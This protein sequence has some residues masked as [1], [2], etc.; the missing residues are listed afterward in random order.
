MLVYI[1]SFWEG[2]EEV[3]AVSEPLVK[4]LR[5]IDG[6]K[7]AMGY[8]YEAMDRAK[9]TIRNYYVGKGTP[10]HNRHMLWGLI[11]SRWTEMLHRPIHAT[12]LLLNSTFSY[13]SNFDFD[14]KVLEGLLTC[15]Q[16]MVPEYET[17]NAINR[18]I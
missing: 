4:V 7:P 17:H 6:D 10:G 12:T 14:D 9:E 5:L 2:I 16:R 11:D 1:D 13:E 3:C 18:N 8:L 15:I